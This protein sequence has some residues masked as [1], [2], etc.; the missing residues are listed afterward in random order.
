MMAQPTTIIW[1]HGSPPG[2]QVLACSHTGGSS[3]G[4]GV[5]MELGV[6]G[7]GGGGEGGG[8]CANENV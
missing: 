7:E 6:R 5:A 3:K 1:Q 4:L 8:G 2:I